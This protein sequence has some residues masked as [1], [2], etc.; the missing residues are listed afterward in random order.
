MKKERYWVRLLIVIPAKSWASCWNWDTSRVYLHSI[1]KDIPTKYHF[2]LHIRLQD[3]CGYCVSLL[4]NVFR[5]VQF[6][7]KIAKLS[8]QWGC[9]QI[10]SRKD[11]VLRSDRYLHL[12]FQSQN[13]L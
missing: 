13:H 5:I 1:F 8:I 4:I 3:E 11:C 6:K 2:Q 9:I 12:K 10:H 7:S